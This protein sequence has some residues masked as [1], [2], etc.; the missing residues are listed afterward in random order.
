MTLHVICHQGVDFVQ[1]LA[2][3]AVHA[4]AG[5]YQGSQASVGQQVHHREEELQRQEWQ[6]GTPLVKVAGL[7]SCCH[8]CCGLAAV[9][10][11][12]GAAVA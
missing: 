2:Q 3:N 6:V 9:G 7:R 11:G 12:S 5:L 10:F 4:A 1:P 8:W